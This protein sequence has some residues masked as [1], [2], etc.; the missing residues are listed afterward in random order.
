MLDIVIV[1]AGGFGREVYQWAKDSLPGDHYRL[2][3]FLSS[4][5]DDLDG[6]GIAEKVLGDDA[7][8]AVQENDRF[9]FAIGNIEAKK[10]SVER[11]KARGIKCVTLIHP[12]AVVASSA[13]IGE[14]VILCPFVL[15][16][17]HV[18]LGDFVMMN[19]YSSCG[20]DTKVGKYGMFSPYATANG[21][22]NMEDEVFLGSHATITGYRKVGAGAKISANSVAMH[23]VP[24]GGFVFGVPGKIKTIFFPDPDPA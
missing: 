14:G 1:G 22:V 7:S 21:F 24:A 13:L 20:H 2:K 15:V 12:T 18:V 6:F 19:F 16:S 11:M 9:V 8:Y 3:G 5:P 23:D 10:H 17:D 4:R